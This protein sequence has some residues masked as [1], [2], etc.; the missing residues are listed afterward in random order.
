[1]E[2]PLPAFLAT[3]VTRIAGMPGRALTPNEI[4]GSTLLSGLAPETEVILTAG[5]AVPPKAVSFLDCRCR[6]CS[7]SYSSCT[8]CA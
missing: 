6:S 2:P 8:S 5:V 7:N 1:M 3:A 4:S